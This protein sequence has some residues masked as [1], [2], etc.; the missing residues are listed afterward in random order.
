MTS[1]QTDYPVHKYTKIFLFILSNVLHRDF[2]AKIVFKF[3]FTF[4]Q[5]EHTL[6]SHLV[7][8]FIQEVVVLRAPS[9]LI[10]CT[11]QLP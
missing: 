10:S 6:T 5:Y 1:L 2:E 4:V 11:E 3:S 9:P 8:N 7:H